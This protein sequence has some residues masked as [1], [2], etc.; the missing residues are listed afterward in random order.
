MSE[1]DGSI[2]DLGEFGSPGWY[3]R[4]RADLYAAAKHLFSLQRERERECEC[5]RNFL[6]AAIRGTLS[7]EIK[8]RCE[9]ADLAR[10]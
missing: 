10:Q 7:L 3:R 1:P 4:L 5:E 2:E 8:H 6:L 9:L